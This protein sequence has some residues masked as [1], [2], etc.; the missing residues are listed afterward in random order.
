MKYI[1]VLGAKSKLAKELAILYA[2]EGFG[3]ILA[4]RDIDTLTDFSESLKSKYNTTVDLAEIDLCE[5]EK[6]EQFYLNLRAKP[7]G[8]IV[9]TGNYIQ[10]GQNEPNNKDILNCI[11][12]NITGPVCLLSFFIE[13]MK[14]LKRGF[15]VG[16]S[17]VSGERGRKKN[18]IYGCSKAAF[19]TYLSGIRNEL[20]NYN[21]HVLSVIC[22]YIKS[23]VRRDGYG[24]YLEA[25][26]SEIA[27]I[28]F[29]GQK[30]NRNIIY[31]KWHW[32][33]VMFIIKIIPE[34]IFK[35]LSI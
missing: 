20:Y 34:F 27:K 7:Y 25:Y 35:R 5:F 6:H 8:I 28:V 30:N 9:A 18:Y 29:D 24:K 26:P 10:Q 33:I 23:D 2:K 12:T 22:G 13:D 21:V 3:I 19:T 1:L 4:G 16:I 31:V 11:N 32:K 17:S 14:K 15:I